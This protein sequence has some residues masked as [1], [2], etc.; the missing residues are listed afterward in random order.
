M[1]RI[2]TR[3]L[4]IPDLRKL[5]VRRRIFALEASERHDPI[6][7]LERDSLPSEPLHRAGT[8]QA[9]HA[10]VQS[11]HQYSA[12]AARSTD[13]RVHELKEQLEEA[14]KP[15]LRVVVREGAKLP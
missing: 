2:L 5:D 12:C 14:L 15:S 11:V 1:E 6:V 3:W 13:P 4:D 8:P 10:L 7:V 9:R